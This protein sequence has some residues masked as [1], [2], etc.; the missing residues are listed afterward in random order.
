MM[1]VLHY[2]ALDRDTSCMCQSLGTMIFGKERV[3]IMLGR[4]IMA[5]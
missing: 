5:A 3:R 1:L 2:A 4:G